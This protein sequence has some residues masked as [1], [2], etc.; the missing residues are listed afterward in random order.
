VFFPSD[1]FLFFD[2]SFTE[3]GLAAAGEMDGKVRLYDPR[4]AGSVVKIVLAGHKA[5]VST[6]SWS[7]SNPQNQV[8][9]E[10]PGLAYFLL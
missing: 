3:A 5:P 1:L 7:P 2:V 6:V 4:G 9:A 8:C 10:C